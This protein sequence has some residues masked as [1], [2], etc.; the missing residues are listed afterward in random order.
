MLSDPKAMN[1]SGLHLRTP[2]DRLVD[3]TFES[4][5]DVMMGPTGSGNRKTGRAIELP[6]ASNRR[7]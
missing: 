5:P 4:L 7:T 2:T 1:L 3:E 6:H